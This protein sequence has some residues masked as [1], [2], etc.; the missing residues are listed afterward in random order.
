M[1][2]RTAWIMIWMFLTLLATGFPAALD[3]SSEVCAKVREARKRYSYY[4]DRSSTQSELE[5]LAA[6]KKLVY[7]QMG[8]PPRTV[9]A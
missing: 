6:K 3:P 1:P 7:T 5:L 4:L 9:E 8:Y 2:T